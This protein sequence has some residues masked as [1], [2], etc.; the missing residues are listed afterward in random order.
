MV[1]LMNTEPT[2]DAKQG[3]AGLSGII[4]LLALIAVLGMAIGVG[5]YA[6]LPENGNKNAQLAGSCTVDEEHRAILDASAKGDVAAFRALDRPY[7]I[8]DLEFNDGD[9]NSVTMANWEGRTVL[10]NLWATWCAPCRKE[11]PAL[12]ALQKQLGGDNFEVVPVSVDL[13]EPDKPKQFYQSI[14]LKNLGFFH[15]PALKTL[16]TLKK[17]GLA[18][19]LPATLLIDKRGCVTGSLNGPAHWDGNDA[20]T[21]IGKEIDS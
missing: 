12:D 2:P 18:Y 10:F 8:R 14:G 4:R 5:L 20:V 21:L 7:S 11:M 19:G 1:T 13:G 16:N 9:G 6:F 17:S 3:R 15:D